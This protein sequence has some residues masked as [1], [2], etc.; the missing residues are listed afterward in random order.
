M[1]LF[2]DNYILHY[3]HISTHYQAKSIHSLRASADTRRQI[4][5]TLPSDA[6]SPLMTSGAHPFPVSLSSTKELNPLM[7]ILKR[8]L[9]APLPT[10][11]RLPKHELALQLPRL[12]QSPRLTDP[13][14]E[15]RAVVV[16]LEITPQPLGFERAP[17][18]EL[19][20]AGAVVGPCG[21]GGCVSKP[22][23][24]GKGVEEGVGGDGKRPKERRGNKDIHSGITSLIIG[25]LPARVAIAASSSNHSTLP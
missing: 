22:C 23:Q 6:A 19:V 2:Q 25:F 3:P 24:I 10:I 18:H 12:R 20:H 8:P 9:P 15:L 14:A 1:L 5:I 21:V 7:H 13:L 16:V 11:R 17:Q 4:C